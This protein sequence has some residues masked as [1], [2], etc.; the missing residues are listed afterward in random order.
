MICRYFLPFCGLSLNFLDSILYHEFLILESSLR[1]FIPSMLFPLSFF[2]F[3]FIL[4]V[5]LCQL[6]VSCNLQANCLYFVSTVLLEHIHPSVA[7]LGLQWW[8]LY[9][10]QS[11]K[12]LLSDPLQKFGH[13]CCVNISTYGHA[14]LFSL[15]HSKGTRPNTLVYTLLF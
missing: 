8:R 11:Q 1:I 7:T 15:F 13:F 9:G 3:L 5:S 12:Y 14:F 10:P 6:S 4:G 2:S